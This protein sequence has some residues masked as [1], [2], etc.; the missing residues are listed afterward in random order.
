MRDVL[1]EYNGLGFSGTNAG[2]NLIIMKSTWRKNRSGIV[3]NSEDGEKNPPQHDAT[4][5]AG[6]DVEAV[7]A[8]VGRRFELTGDGAAGSGLRR[9]GPSMRMVMQ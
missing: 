5:V 9:D 6:R 7:Q 3:P 4:I 1:G 2:G 8:W